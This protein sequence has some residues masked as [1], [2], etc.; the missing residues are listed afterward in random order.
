MFDIIDDEKL[1]KMTRRDQ[2]FD[3]IAK[4][5]DFSKQ[6]NDEKYCIDFRDSTF[7]H[8]SYLT[9][10]YEQS[11][12]SIVFYYFASNPRTN[13]QAWNSMKT[14]Y[15]FFIYNETII[16]NT[17]LLGAQKIES[18]LHFISSNRVNQYH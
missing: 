6:N 7:Q 9:T 15:T 11:I 3:I 13:F 14:L 4:E 8:P 18:H 10:L 12:S 2:I 1:L 17:L 5:Y 16:K